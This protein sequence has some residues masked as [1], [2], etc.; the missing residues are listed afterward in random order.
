MNLTG[1]VYKAALLKTK[2]G[3]SRGV[4][5]NA[6]PLLL[7]AI[8]EAIEKGVI[9]GNKIE[10]TNSELDKIYKRLSTTAHDSEGNA[11]G[12]K[13]TVTPLNMPFF[14]LNA[15]DYYHLKWKTDVEHPKQAQS[16]SAKYIRENI[17][18]AYLDPE[19]W[20]L[21]Q[22]AEVRSEFREAIINHYLVN[23]KK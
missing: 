10:F 9:I 1:I 19:L 21:L 4:F 22:D 13:V 2:R 12:E 6:K 23:S 3:N 11:I 16:P 17:A 15:E 18:Y 8:M 7:L 5:S 20:D 14:H